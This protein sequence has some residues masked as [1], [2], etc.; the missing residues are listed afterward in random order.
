MLYK[1]GLSKED[2]FCSR[3]E[4]LWSSTDRHAES[5]RAKN[6][7][8]LNGISL[9]NLLYQTS[10]N[11]EEGKVEKVWETEDMEGNKNTIPSKSAWV[12]LRNAQRPRQQEWALQQVPWIYITASNLV[13]LCGSPGCEWVTPL[14]FPRHFS[15]YLFVLLNFDVIAFIILCI[16]LLYFISIS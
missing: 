10:G 14:H 3:W 7:K 11:P 2:S 8:L 4:Q 5:E 15:L 9:S 16:I 1:G 12:K 13:V 6:S